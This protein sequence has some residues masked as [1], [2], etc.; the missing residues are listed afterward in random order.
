[1]FPFYRNTTALKIH[2]WMV[3]SEVHHNWSEPCGFYDRMK[4]C[5]TRNAQVQNVPTTRVFLSEHTSTI[6]S[7]MNSLDVDHNQSYPG[8]DH[9]RV[10]ICFTW[11][12]Q[13]RNLLTSRC[14]FL[15]GY[16]LKFAHG[17]LPRGLNSTS[18]WPKWV[19]HV[20]L[21][22]VDRIQICLFYSGSAGSKPTDNFFSIKTRWP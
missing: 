8:G 15:S 4:I 17:R 10:K 7:W 14:F 1:M 9:N 5:P 16:A 13:V 6:W 2:S 20:V 11:V 21:Y 18:S 22:I 12:T 19:P 3:S